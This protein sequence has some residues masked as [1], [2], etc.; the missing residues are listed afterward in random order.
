MKI[1][2]FIKSNVM[3]FIFALCAIVLIENNPVFAQNGCALLKKD[4]PVIFVSFE[5][6]VEK[7]KKR[8]VQLR[9]NNNS[10]CTIVVPVDIG[11]QTINGSEVKPCIPS[12]FGELENNS[13]VF[14][15]YHITDPKT[16]TIYMPGGGD[17]RSSALLKGG[18]SVIFEI[19]VK[20]YKKGDF[21][22]AFNY[23]WEVGNDR[24][25]MVILHH[26]LSFYS[27]ELQKLIK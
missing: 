17:V 19:P 18:N 12:T 7:D 22:L 6:I 4:D 15:D 24:R 9:L 23:D 5:R 2:V 27:S 1:L 25:E 16:R 13:T 14:L 21:S 20:E 11:Q 8:I 10:T 3:V 26:E